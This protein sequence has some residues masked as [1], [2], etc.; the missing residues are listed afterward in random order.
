MIRRDR[1]GDP[2]AIGMARHDRLAALGRDDGSEVVSEV[3]KV[4]SS[5]GPCESPT[6]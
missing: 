4:T 2:L 3:V 5:I 1:L 6:L